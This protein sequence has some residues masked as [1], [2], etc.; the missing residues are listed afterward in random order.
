MEGDDVFLGCVRSGF[1][2]VFRL[3]FICC[4]EIEVGFAY[5]LRV[6]FFFLDY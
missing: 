2:V 6:V 1:T 3:E 4:I 5:K